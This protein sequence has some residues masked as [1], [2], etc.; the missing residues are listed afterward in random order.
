LFHV[1]H[2]VKLF[3]VEQFAA[4]GMTPFRGTAL[5]TIATDTV[6]Q[7]QHSHRCV[8]TAGLWFHCRFRQRV[9]R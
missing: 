3:H 7:L 8:I 4:P 6:T 9:L 1:E 5:A 2:S